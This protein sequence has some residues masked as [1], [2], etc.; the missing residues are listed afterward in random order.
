[1]LKKGTTSW[2]VRSLMRFA[3]DFLQ[4]KGI[5]EARRNAELLMAH[6]L[7]CPR[8][9]LY[10]NPSKVISKKEFAF[11]KGFLERRINREPLQ[12]IIGTANFMGLLLRVDRRVL[13]PRPETESLVEQTMLLCGSM[14]QKKPIPILD[15]GTGSGNIPIALAKYVK[16]CEVTS[17][18]VSDDVLEIARFNALLHEVAD[19]IDFRRLSVF[20]PIDQI[21]L[22]RFAILVSNPPYVSSR[23]WED[24]QME[25]RRFEPKEAVSDGKDGFEFHRRIIARSRRSDARSDCHGAGLWTG[26]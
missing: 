2:N 24:L 6:A 1:M 11:Y 14:D 22:R 16:H 18:D 15:I 26:G 4:E 3:I 13:I 12:Y 9:D 17:I 10:T 20:E 8:I 21:L 7:K 25:I 23:E 19:R 5:E